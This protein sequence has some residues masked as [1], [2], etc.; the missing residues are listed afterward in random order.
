MYTCILV[1]HLQALLLFQF[2]FFSARVQLMSICRA[3][4]DPVSH[5]KC[6]DPRFDAMC[7]KPDPT[8]SS[9]FYF[10]YDHFHV[11]WCNFWIDYAHFIYPNLYLKR[12]LNILAN[13]MSCFG[14]LGAWWLLYQWSSFGCLG[15]WVH[16]R[17]ISLKWDTSQ[18][19]G[20]CLPIPRSS[21]CGLEAFFVCLG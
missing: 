15:L 18:F 10:V 5:L 17:W 14:P 1:A 3:H 13:H 2:T 20:F 16:F 19:S 9:S 11:F 8:I 12:R 7:F 6:P 21:G 4:A